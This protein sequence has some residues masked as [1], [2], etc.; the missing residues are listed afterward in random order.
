MFFNVPT[1]RSKAYSSYYCMHI[2]L[3][4]IDSC[5]VFYSVLWAHQQLWPNLVSGP[6]VMSFELWN[7]AHIIKNLSRQKA[8]YFALSTSWKC[9]HYADSG[10]IVCFVTTFEQSEFHLW[11]GK[12]CGK[13][14]LKISTT[15]MSR[16]NK[17]CFTGS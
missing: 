4:V 5:L 9:I 17:L 11:N 13:L 6:C 2:I 12:L 7:K 15:F 16:R 8:H 3:T 14:L 10:C 1:K